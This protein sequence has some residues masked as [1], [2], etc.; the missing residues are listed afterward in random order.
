MGR[1]DTYE[2]K[3]IKYVSPYNSETGTNISFLKSCKEFALLVF[4]KGFYN[5]IPPLYLIEASFKIASS[6]VWKCNISLTIS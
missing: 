5:N 6:L 2:I 3:T 1:N 4:W